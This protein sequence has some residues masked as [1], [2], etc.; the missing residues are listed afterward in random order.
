MFDVHSGVSCLAFAAAKG[1][2]I[3]GNWQQK[4]FDVVYD[5]GKGRIGFAGGGCG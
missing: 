1:V 5:V 4:T 3:I 2:T